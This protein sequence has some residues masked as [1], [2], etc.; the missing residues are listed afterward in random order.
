MNDEFLTKFHRTPRAEF[1]DAL[2]ERISR[3]PQP[4]F[5]QALG[6]RLTLRNSVIMIVLLFVVVACVYAVTEKRWNKVGDIWVEVQK[7]YKVEFIPPPEISE[8]PETQPQDYECLTV[9]EA[10]TV[11]RFDLRVPAWAPEGFTFD[12]RICGID[13]LS[14]FASLYWVGADKYSGISIML[15]NRRGF[16]MSTQE[17]EIWPPVIWGPVAPGSYEEV[18]VHEQ[19]AVLV[20]GDWEEPWMIEGMIEGKYEFKWDKK[21]ALQLYWVEGEVLYHL[22]TRA[23]VS[24]ED[25]IRMAESAR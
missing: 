18:Q 14:D 4:S 23:H 24:A 20:H 25:L 6:Q 19:P 2:Y 15:S 1:A 13:R 7:T 3:E 11:L 22:Y 16:N 12:D 21:R 10:T 17:Y 9:E 8:V 5:A